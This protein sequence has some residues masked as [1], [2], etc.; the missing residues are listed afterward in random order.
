LDWKPEINEL[1]EKVTSK[2]PEAFRD[3]VKPM[4]RQA[5][6][7]AAIVRN[8]AYVSK[9]DLLSSLFDITPEAFKPTVVQDLE[10]LGIDSSRYIKLSDVRKEFSR[11][12]DE[13]GGAFLPGVFH[14]TM[15][16]T[17][18][19]NQKC[20]HCAAEAKT[21]RPELS[22]EQW[23]QIIENVEQTLRKRGRRGCYIWFGGDPTLRKDLKDLIKYCGEKGYYQ[24]VSTNGILFDE[25]LARLCAEVKMSH[26]FISFDTVYPE[27]AAI[28]RGVPKA[29][30]AAKKAIDLSLKYGNFTIITATVQKMN[31]DELEEIKDTM[32]EWGVIPYFRAVIKQRNAATN[33]DQI[34]LNDDE[35]RK[36]YDFKYGIVTDTIKRGDAVSLNK[37]ATYDMVPFMECPINDKER[38]SLEWGVGCQ[39]CRSV[40]G[41]DIN[42]DF[43][44]CDYP[45]ELKL[46]N[47]LEQDFGEIMDSKLFKDIRDRVRTGK[48]ASCHHLEMCGGGC[49]VHAECETGDFFASFPYCWHEMDHEHEENIDAPKK[50]KVILPK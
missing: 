8:S 5:A 40:S 42:G 38:T 16:L 4:L 29:Y 9:D 47:V 25:E 41:I 34:G 14:F 33:W 32:D 37:F 27:R 3:S 20:L 26:V 39:A 1:Y 28:I 30:E 36:F 15:Y 43:F 7:K 22:T 50:Q 17:D 10:D 24:A 13:I 49:R 19:C 31:I 35:Y 12:W 45:S 18:R 6:E 44:P 11:T 48:C 23:I 21:H 46:G 2:V